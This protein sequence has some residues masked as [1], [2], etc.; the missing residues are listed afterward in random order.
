MSPID[1]YLLTVI[2]SFTLDVHNDM[3]AQQYASY[4]AAEAS[5][6]LA[7]EILPRCSVTRRYQEPLHQE[8]TCFEVCAL[9]R[10]QMHELLC[11]AREE[12]Y[13][14]AISRYTLDAKR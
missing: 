12:G 6:R 5:H 7:A 2:V 4:S 3:T 8:Q 11:R 14:A 9:T 1:P 13:K 10:T